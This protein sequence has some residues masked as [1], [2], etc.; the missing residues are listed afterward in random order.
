M[1]GKTKP[2]RLTLKQPPVC[3]T[4]RM[5]FSG[6]ETLSADLEPHASPV[7]SEC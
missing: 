2:K 5:A 4:H 3:K 6:G 7:V 1:G